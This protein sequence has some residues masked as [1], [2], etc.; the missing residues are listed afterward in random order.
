MPAATRREKPREIAI[1]A[2]PFPVAKPSPDS[3]NEGSPPSGRRSSDSL[4]TAADSPMI[5]TIDGPAGAGKSSAAR[6]LARRLGFR[7]LDTGAM[8]RAVALA[9]NR[10]GVD[11]SDP[12]ELAAVAAEPDARSSPTTASS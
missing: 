4:R 2:A 9:G 10:R 7:F 6:R 12:A 1:Q 5:V 3:D 8:Y 11:W